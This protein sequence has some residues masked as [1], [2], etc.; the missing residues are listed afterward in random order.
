MDE[1]LRILHGEIESRV[2]AIRAARDWPCRK[3]CDYCCRHLAAPPQ[4]T[5]AE[6]QL[7]DEGIARLPDEL[8]QQI[9]GRLT[10]L[11]SASRPI[12]C[13]YLDLEARACLVYDCRPVA[14]RTY[15]YYVERDGGQY[16]T[17]IE[18]MVNRGE[19]KDVVWGNG[20]AVTARLESL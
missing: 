7:L 9:E 8:H 5:A 19:C 3:G 12:V 18:A 13:P 4:L 20:E 14:C 17:E 16:C 2:D 15:G 1:R 11:A 10:A 6:R